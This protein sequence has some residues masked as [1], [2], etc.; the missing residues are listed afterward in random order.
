[1][2]KLLAFLLAAC[3]LLSLAACAKTPQQP[4][5]APTNAEKPT[6]AEQPTEPAA[7]QTF[8]WDNFDDRDPNAK[9]DTA[10]NGASMW[11]DNC[12]EPHFPSRQK[13]QN[14]RAH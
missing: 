13:N 2:K 12:L 6:E 7:P 3:M 11:W 8:L 4:T 10:P 5:T 1:M 14:I 9:P